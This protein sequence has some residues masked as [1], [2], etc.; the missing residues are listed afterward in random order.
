MENE[1]LKMEGYPCQRLKDERLPDGDPSL[2]LC[3]FGTA[4]YRSG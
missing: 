4:L 2:R 3:V 1:K